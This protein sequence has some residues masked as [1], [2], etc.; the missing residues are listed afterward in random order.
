MGMTITFRAAGKLRR[1]TTRRIRRSG[2]V[3]VLLVL[4][5]ALMMSGC[6]SNS[7]DNDS[8]SGSSATA[9]STATNAKVCQDLKDV[10]TSVSQLKDIPLSKDGLSTL[11]TKLDQISTQAHQLAKD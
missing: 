10:K 8:G 1:M 7:S 9:G 2:Q 3:A 4:P 5:T 11:S 6:G